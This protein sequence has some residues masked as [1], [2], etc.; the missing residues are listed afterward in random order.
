[1]AKAMRLDEVT[2]GISLKKRDIQELCLGQFN[3]GICKGDKRVVVKVGGK[4]EDVVFWKL[5]EQSI[6]KRSE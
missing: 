6:S 5:S 4:P 2:K 1:M 3:E